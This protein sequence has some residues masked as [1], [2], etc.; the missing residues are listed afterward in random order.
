MS[1]IFSGLTVYAGKWSVKEEVVL[2]AEDRALFSSAKV[3]S[4]DF[5]KSV[6]FF[7]KAGGQN[8][9]PLSTEGV[10]PAVGD[11]VNLEKCTVQVLEKQGEHDI[12]RVKIHD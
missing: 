11:S 8:F 7:L 2:D 3:V 5:G 1:N 9:I 10:Q 4:S 12:L 6:C